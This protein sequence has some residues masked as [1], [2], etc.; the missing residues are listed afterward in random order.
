MKKLNLII[1]FIVISI[2]STTHASTSA[3]V[4]KTGK[5]QKTSKSI[6]FSCCYNRHTSDYGHWLPSLANNKVCEVYGGYKAGNCELTGNVPLV[7][8]KTLASLEEQ[9]KKIGYPYISTP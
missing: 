6:Y 9:C 3:A 8:R 2:Y 1:P 7:N 4:C 5:D